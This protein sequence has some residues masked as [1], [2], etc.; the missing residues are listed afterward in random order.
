MR[1]FLSLDIENEAVMR[2]M[3]RAEE[4]LAST[5]ADLKLVERQNLHFTVKFFGEIAESQVPEIDK[6]IG[7]LELKQID[8]RVAGV[9]VFPDL[10]SPRVVWVG[11]APPDADSVTSIGESVIAAVQG[12]GQ[13]EDHEFHPHITLARVRSGRNKQ[14]LA[15]YVQENA[16]RAFGASPI[17]TLKLKSSVL[18]PNGPTYTDV[19]VYSL[20]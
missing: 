16:A 19:K 4:E 13:P 12:I 5:G 20:R 10:R 1:A 11:V 6:R 3:V 18:G 14:E 17:R 2:E 8:A 7:D 15:R 9:G